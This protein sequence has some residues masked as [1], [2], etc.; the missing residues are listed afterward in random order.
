MSWPFRERADSL[1]YSPAD[2]QRVCVLRSWTTHRH[3]LFRVFSP[4]CGKHRRLFSDLA[5]RLNEKRVVR[6]AGVRAVPK[7]RFGVFVDAD[8]FLTS[9]NIGANVIEFNYYRT[10]LYLS[11]F[12]SFPRDDMSLPDLCRRSSSQGFSGGIPPHR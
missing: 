2:C 12:A 5:G 8:H 1:R 10:S 3:A 9:A 6:Q 11:R 7:G 4:V